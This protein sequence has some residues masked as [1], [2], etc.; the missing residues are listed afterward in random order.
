[1]PVTFGYVQK[2]MMKISIYTLRTFVFA[3][4]TILYTAADETAPLGVS[5]NSRF[6]C[7]TANGRMAFKVA[8]FD[9]ELHSSRR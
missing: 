1:M 4:S 5:A 3:V 7:P 9:N 2:Q 6:L 8:L